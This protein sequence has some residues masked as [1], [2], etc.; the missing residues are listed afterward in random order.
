[1]PIY[2][3][4]CMDCGRKFDLLIFKNDENVEC[5][6]C[7]KSNVSKLFSTFA[8]ISGKNEIPSECATGGC[9]TGKCDRR[10]CPGLQLDR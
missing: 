9:Q 7:K 8:S 2:E 6:A 3:Y 10:K 4:K 5:P 1:M